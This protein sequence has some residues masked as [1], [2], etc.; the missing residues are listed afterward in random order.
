MLFFFSINFRS[1]T[2]LSNATLPG[3]YRPRVHH[4]HPVKMVEMKKIND[5][6]MVTLFFIQVNVT[7]GAT[8]TVCD[9]FWMYC[10]HTI[11]KDRYLTR[12][13]SSLLI[14]STDHGGSVHVSTVVVTAGA[15]G[16]INH[17][18]GHLSQNRVWSSAWN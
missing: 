10:P 18:D 3:S 16:L 7:I 14:P 4:C 11:N 1:I 12:V 17:W 6:C 8:K 9:I 2:N 15:G 5:I 13:L